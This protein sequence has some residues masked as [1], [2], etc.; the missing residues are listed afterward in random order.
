[1]DDYGTHKIQIGR[2]LRVCR[3]AHLGSTGRNRGPRQW[4]GNSREV[5]WNPSLRETN[6]CKSANM[7]FL[8]QATR[9]SEMVTGSKFGLTGSKFDPVT[10]C[11]LSRGCIPLEGGIP[12]EGPSNG[13]GKRETGVTSASLESEEVRRQHHGKHIGIGYSFHP[14]DRVG[15]SFHLVVAAELSVARKTGG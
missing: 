1:M 10:R 12:F 6:A 11:L 2:C 4:Q 5:V 13:E 9:W 7:L 14:V 15:C 8:A 3:N